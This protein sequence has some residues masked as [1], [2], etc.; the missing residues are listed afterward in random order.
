MIV[1]DTAALVALERNDRNLWVRLDEA[2]RADIPVVVPLGALAQAWR[3][4]PRQARLARAL[5]DLDQA[6]FDDVALIAGEVCGKVGTADVVDAS[7]AVVAARPEITHLYTSDPD[8][9][10]PLIRAAGRRRGPQIVPC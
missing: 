2:V 1:F 7:I 8:D 3:G 6:S 10:R 9:L 5:R 4:G